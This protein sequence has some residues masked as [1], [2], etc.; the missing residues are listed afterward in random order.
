MNSVLRFSIYSVLRIRSTV[1]VRG[2]WLP[3]QKNLNIDY[4][5]MARALNC[6]VLTGA[7]YG[8]KRS[9]C[10]PGDKN[11]SIWIDNLNPIS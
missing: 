1:S 10:E 3:F 4:K 2:S 6:A 5:F 9:V 7:S 8:G 11:E